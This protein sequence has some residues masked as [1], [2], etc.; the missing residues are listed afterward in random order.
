MLIMSGVWCHIVVIIIS[1]NT[2]KILYALGR[3]ERAKNIIIRTICCV[4]RIGLYQNWMIVVCIYDVDVGQ[5]TADFRS[6]YHHTKDNVW[7]PCMR[8]TS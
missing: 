3:Q 4:N 5:E 8:K 6:S 2:L 7:F 1:Q